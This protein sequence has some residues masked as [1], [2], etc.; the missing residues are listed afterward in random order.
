MA[1]LFCISLCFQEPSGPYIAEAIVPNSPFKFR[2]L[3]TSDQPFEYQW[4]APVLEK[5]HVAFAG[6]KDLYR[7]SSIDLQFRGVTF[8]IDFLRQGSCFV[9]W[10]AV[11]TGHIPGTAWETC[12][13]WNR[14]DGFF[15]LAV[16]TQRAEVGLFSKA[17]RPFHGEIEHCKSSGKIRWTSGHPPKWNFR[18]RTIVKTSRS[19]SLSHATEANSR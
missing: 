5:N 2:L 6:R 4:K 1:S 12:V 11:V 3:K 19:G 9:L 7:M 14:R 16:I 10:T 17:S 8:L 13:S 15:D 18:I